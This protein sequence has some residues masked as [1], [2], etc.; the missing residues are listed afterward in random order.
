[1][2]R[3]R[4]PLGKRAMTDAE[5]Q[6]RRREREKITRTDH[7]RAKRLRRSL[8]RALDDWVDD[9]LASLT[10]AAVVTDALHDLLSL[11]TT[12]RAARG[13]YGRDQ[14]LDGESPSTDDLADLL[15]RDR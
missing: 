5:R 15:N 9:N 3:G 14:Y 10:S 7:E 13:Q 11:I 1:M 8:L 2:A 4:K 12:P 6:H